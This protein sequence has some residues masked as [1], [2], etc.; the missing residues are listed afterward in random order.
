MPD[1]VKAFIQVQES[2]MPKGVE[3][4]QRKA[5]PAAM[6]MPSAG[7]VD[8]ESAGIVDAERR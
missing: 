3:H 2:L 5:A 8:A 1:H 7:I 4:S 6:P